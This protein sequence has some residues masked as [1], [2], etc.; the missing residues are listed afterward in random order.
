MTSDSVIGWR[1]LDPLA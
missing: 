1:E